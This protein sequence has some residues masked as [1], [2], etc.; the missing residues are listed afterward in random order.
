MWIERRATASVFEQLVGPRGLISPFVPSV[1]KP[2][3]I[4]ICNSDRRAV[5]VCQITEDQ[6]QSGPVGIR[7]QSIPLRGLTR[8]QDDLRSLAHID[9]VH[10]INDILHLQRTEH[11]LRIK[12]KRL[13]EIDILGLGQRTDLALASASACSV[14]DNF[15]RDD[16]CVFTGGG[17]PTGN[18]P[19]RQKRIKSLGHS[20]RQRLV[21][22][23]KTCQLQV[24]CGLARRILKEAACNIGVLCRAVFIGIVHHAIS[25]GQISLNRRLD[26][27]TIKAV[28][29]PVIC[30]S[31][32]ICGDRSIA[33]PRL[34]LRPNIKIDTATIFGAFGLRIDA[35]NVDI[36]HQRG[37][38]ERPQ[39]IM[40][41]LE[42][43]QCRVICGLDFFGC[44]AAHKGA[45]HIG[46]E[47]RHIGQNRL[48]AGICVDGFNVSAHVATSADI[49][50]GQRRMK[51]A[52]GLRHVACKIIQQPAV[53]F[54][55]KGAH[56]VQISRFSPA[57]DQVV[58]LL[59]SLGVTETCVVFCRIN[60]LEAGKLLRFG[61]CMGQHSGEVC[62]AFINSQVIGGLR[63]RYCIRDQRIERGDVSQISINRASAGR[64]ADQVPVVHVDLIIGKLFI[65]ELLPCDGA[66]AI[67]QAKPRLIG[68]DARVSQRTVGF[69]VIIQNRPREGCKTDYP[70][71]RPNGD[72]PKVTIR[73]LVITHKA[74]PD[75]FRFDQMQIASHLDHVQAKP[76]STREAA[77]DGQM[78]GIDPQGALGRANHGLARLQLDPVG[79]DVWISRIRQRRCKDAIR[80]ADIDQTTRGPS[81][82]DDDEAIRVGVGAKID[83]DFLSGFDIQFI[84]DIHRRTNRR[85][86]VGRGRRCD[87]RGQKQKRR[88]RAAGACAERLSRDSL[89]CHL[90]LRDEVH[91][92]R[93]EDAVRADGLQLAG[94]RHVLRGDYAATV[95]AERS[96][97][98]R[99]FPV[100]IDMGIGRRADIARKVH[101]THAFD[102]HSRDHA[103]SQKLDVD[104]VAR[105]QADVPVFLQALGGGGLTVLGLFLQIAAAFG[106]FPLGLV[107]VLKGR[108]VLTGIT[109]VCIEALAGYR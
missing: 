47:A 6:I 43:R 44:F 14:Q 93:V 62:F 22:A 60:G 61:L 100:D 63:R 88:R 19:N 85:R 39:R 77:I 87:R 18:R 40:G 73:L 80:R 49:I 25:I 24:D 74:G 15:M 105:L 103:A 106:P 96:A 20:G 17:C 72:R 4:T 109:I 67:I 1:P 35:H 50:I 98:R 104:R 34:E 27:C 101:F 75:V 66:I 84:W 55:D 58:I 52:I 42:P 10:D 9:L 46:L 89:L 45:R 37:V 71:K 54:S 56:L 11:I 68:R 16:V 53:N 28:K 99:E 108:Q 82:F 78:I 94:N 81:P 65:I 3:N 91:Q 8:G 48:V 97:G 5:S 51:R 21:Q 33:A 79:P 7:S 59:V 26:R 83:A 107:E 41:R 95:H 38:V 57:P 13:G 23:G 12:V 36:G 69:K 86:H 102:P 32:Y 2:Q 30:A 29:Q 76:C 64:G 70:L 31:G 92:D 90:G